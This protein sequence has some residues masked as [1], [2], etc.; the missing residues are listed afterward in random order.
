MASTLTG[1][2]W[3]DAEPTTGQEDVLPI[4]IKASADLRAVT[5]SADGKQ[6][7]SSGR[8]G[9]EVWQVQ[10]GQRM[11][12]IEAKGIWCLAVLKGCVYRDVGGEGRILQENFLFAVRNV[13]GRRHVDFHQRL[14][15]GDCNTRAYDHEE[16]PDWTPFARHGLA[17]LMPS[18][19]R[20]YTAKRQLEYRTRM[21][22][23]VV[24]ELE[25]RASVTEGE[26]MLMS[27]AQ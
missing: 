26:D 10:D 15:N 22:H 24:H 23:M 18:R 5:F 20:R 16:D 4:E 19:A 1:A 25:P 2:H 6:L 8:N 21:K 9:V 3:Q 12:T 27:R 17:Y 14:E 7:F 11:A 13:H